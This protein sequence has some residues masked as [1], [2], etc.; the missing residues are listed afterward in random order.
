M[1][2]GGD[3]FP[4]MSIAITAPLIATPVAAVPE[5]GALLALEEDDTEDLLEIEAL[6]EIIELLMLE[7]ESEELLTEIEL[8]L[9]EELDD[10]LDGKLD[11]TVDELELKRLELRALEDVMG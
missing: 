7:D 1:V 5:M 11:E 9:L 4:L 3:I 2:A 6:L 10:K 8:L